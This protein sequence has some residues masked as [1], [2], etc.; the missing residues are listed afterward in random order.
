MPYDGFYLEQ[1]NCAYAPHRDLARRSTS[2]SYS[3]F[4]PLHEDMLLSCQLF[5]DDSGNDRPVSPG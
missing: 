4:E 2:Y 1:N 5:I 3:L